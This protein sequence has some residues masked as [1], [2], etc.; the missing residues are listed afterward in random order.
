[1]PTS[2]P[3][4]PPPVAPP[5]VAVPA[6]NLPP[7]PRRGA[8]HTQSASSSGGRERRQTFRAGGGQRQAA[9][10]DSMCEVCHQRP[11]LQEP[12]QLSGRIATHPFCGITC[13]STAQSSRCRLGDCTMQA[14]PG[15]YHCSDAHAKEV[16]R[17]REV[18]ACSN[19]KEFPVNPDFEFCS[20]RCAL[21]EANNREVGPLRQ[22][23]QQDPALYEILSRFQTN[24]QPSPADRLPRPDV[25]AIYTITLPKK[26][27]KR[28]A[29]AL[30][31]GE[32]L[33]GFITKTSYYG[34]PCLCDIGA[35]DE[36]YPS[37]CNSPG[38]S[39]C[40]VLQ[41]G[42]DV[43]EF[44]KLSHKGQYG[45]GIYTNQNSS[46]AHKFTVGKSTNPYRAIISCAV[47][48]PT[49]TSKPDKKHPVI[50][51]DTGRICCAT[52]DTIIPRHLIIYKVV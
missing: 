20:K 14:S 33:G 22:M 29:E 51:D 49:Q 41:K 52:K 3:A 44:G 46:R 12:D 37:F 21:Q 42:F 23:D 10:D 48:S 2:P 11:K 5:P 25:H 16:V 4:A 19:C 24:W 13:A 34:G 1:M 40:T 47:V 6:S 36:L 35:N 18:A 50:M 17:N 8:F 26:Y 9:P 31:R 28:Y 38:C 15:D 39:I 27:D 7:Q 30:E 45:P 43:L 32:N